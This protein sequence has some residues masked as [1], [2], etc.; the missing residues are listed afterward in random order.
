M[1]TPLPVVEQPVRL[2]RPVASAGHTSKLLNQAGAEHE[3]THAQ[4][5]ESYNMIETNV[6]S[7]RGARYSRLGRIECEGSH[8][9]SLEILEFVGLEV[10]DDADGATIGLA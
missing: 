6:V 9:A 3:Y 7:Q 10:H 4:S 5:G 8:R 2:G 1:D